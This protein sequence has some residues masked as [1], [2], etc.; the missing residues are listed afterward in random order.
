MYKVEIIKGDIT[1]VPANAIV[2]P[3]NSYG[4][5]GGGV[6][7]AIKKAGGE[8][9]EKEAIKKAPIPVGRAI[10]T[11]AGKLN[12]KYVIHAPTMERPAMRTT[13]DKVKK[14]VIAALNVAEE[15]NLSSIAF[16]GM[17]TGVGGV[18]PL[19]AAK[20]MKEAIEEKKPKIEKIL[21]VAFDEELYRA[22]SEVF[23]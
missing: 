5:M 12:A 8:E 7:Y 19:E 10:H 3:A 9:I 21:L 23:G 22:F 6:A 15:L 2:N 18:K 1:K 11:T 14:A 16:P 13:V 20:A 17:G 4:Y